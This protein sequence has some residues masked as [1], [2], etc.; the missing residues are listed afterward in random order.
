MRS[1]VFTLF[2]LIPLHV[3]AATWTLEAV[4]FDDGTIAQGSFDYDEGTGLFSNVNITTS[5]GDFSGY[6]YVDDHLGG[7]G[8]SYIFLAT[9]YNGGGSSDHSLHLSFSSSL[10]GLSFVDLNEGYEKLYVHEGGGTEYEVSLVSGSLVSE[11]PIPA[12]VWLFGSALLGLG[13]IKRRK[14]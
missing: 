5:G 2:F 4:V 13:A 9:S 11:V 7:A 1:L 14:A 6:T 8:L 3:S 12:A 10:D